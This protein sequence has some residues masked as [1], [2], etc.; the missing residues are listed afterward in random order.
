MSPGRLGLSIALPL[1]VA[2]GGAAHAQV[3]RS[4]Q[5][6]NMLGADAAL[7]NYGRIPA[8]A[9]TG[10]G[11]GI[12]LGES[13]TLHAGIGSELGYDTNIFFQRRDEVGAPILR[14]LPFLELNNATRGGERPAGVY[15]DLTANLLYRQ[16]L[17][18]DP[19]AQKQTA[20]NPVA[21]GT[22]IFG[23]GQ[24]LS[25]QLT[26]AFARF[27]E[28]PYGPSTGNITR[29]SN[30]GSLSLLMA[31]GGGRFEFRVGYSNLIS[32]FENPELKFAN[33]M[34]HDFLLD[35]AWKWMPKTAL[36]LQ[37]AQ[38]IVHYFDPDRDPRNARADSFPLRTLA[39][40]RGLITNKLA[41][42]LG[43]G[44]SNGFYSR[45][46]G[47]STG[48][49]NLAAVAEVSYATSEISS[50]LLGYRHEF[51]NSPVLGDFYNVDAVYAILSWLV[52]QRLQLQGYARFELREFRGGTLS[53]ARD[54]AFLQVG[55]SADVFLTSW[56]YAG[57]SYI[58]TANDSNQADLAMFMDSPGLNYQKHLILG[59]LGITY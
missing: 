52:A 48:T 34:G 22:L 56:L 10:T 53:F 44:Y 59:R 57:A 11:N 18:D 27:E 19:N 20:F 17:T 12:S 30:Q 46:G 31:P 58:L 55:G 5:G 47:A 14:L 1:V 23:S 25:L 49:N 3:P 38:G 2:L 32:V 54:D 29:I 6:L 50:L 45:T 15:Y 26:D 8:Q 37:A 13:A 39:G 24:K 28:P 7:G 21:M 42:H 40:L 4:G 43:A 51:R 16:F 9:A 33:H 35:V 41:V 36:Y